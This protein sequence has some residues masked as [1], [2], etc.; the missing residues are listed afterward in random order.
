MA[1]Q[2]HAFFEDPEGYLATTTATIPD[3]NNALSLKSSTF[4]QIMQHVSH[5]NLLSNVFAFSM[6]TD[7]I[8]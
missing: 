8:T 1:G 5:Q 4:R 7:T 6:T 2:I 3:S